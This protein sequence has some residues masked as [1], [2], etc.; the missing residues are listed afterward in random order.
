VPLAEPLV[1]A[2][3]QG[4]FGG[5]VV[6]QGQDAPRGGPGIGAWM[7]TKTGTEWTSM[8]GWPLPRPP[9]CG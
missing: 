9:A 7:L 1:Q 5:Q 2:G 6:L 8:K 4:A 3:G